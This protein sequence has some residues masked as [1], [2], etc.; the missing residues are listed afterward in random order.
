MLELKL[1]GF[2]N[3]KRAEWSLDYKTL[4]I[5]PNGVGKTSILESLYVVNFAQSWRTNRDQEL[6]KFGNDFL[7]VSAVFLDNNYDLVFSKLNHG[8]NKKIVHNGIQLPV[9]RSI[10]GLPVVL[11][12]PELIEIITTSPGQ[13]RRWVDTV[14]SVVDYD[15]ALD[16][17][18]YKH[19]LKQRN[20]LLN[21]PRVGDD[22]FGPW[23]SLIRDYGQRIINKRTALVGFANELIGESYHRLA[24]RKYKA[25]I[26][27]NA[28]H[29]FEDL[30]VLRNKERILG[31]TI[32]GPHRD[33]ILF[34]LDNR[35]IGSGASRG[36][37]R[38]FL[39][40]LKLIEIDFVKTKIRKHQP[41]LLLDDIFSE[42]DNDR[43]HNLFKI[44]KPFPTIITATDSVKLDSILVKDS[45]VI[46]LGL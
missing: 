32:T 27:Y 8:V 20:R 13:R 43:N 26:V 34:K 6:I 36:E 41:I 5:G 40:A 18:H 39:F 31:N 21:T 24:G 37:Q 3:I 30:S 44:I 4:I 38:T 22:E 23:E 15:Y 45:K 33:E 16:L 17:A 12:A 46:E 11:F 7:R 10:G 25:K 29:N 1:E 19:A 35:L 42:L 28:S 9:L 2:R 14:I